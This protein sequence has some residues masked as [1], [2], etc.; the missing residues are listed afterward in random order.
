MGNI[1]MIAAAWNPVHQWHGGNCRTQS[2]GN[3]I[4]IMKESER[5]GCAELGKER[6]KGEEIVQT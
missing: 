4:M 1:I 3:I 6:K 5:E 2:I